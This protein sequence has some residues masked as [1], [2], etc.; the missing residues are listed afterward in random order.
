MV[1][2]AV[3]Y[4]IVLIR[5]QRIFLI[6]NLG[7]LRDRVG[8]LRGLFRLEIVRGTLIMIISWMLHYKHIAAWEY[9]RNSI[10]SYNKKKSPGILTDLSYS[11]QS[12]GL[13]TVLYGIFPAR[14]WHSSFSDKYQGC[15]GQLAYGPFFNRLDYFY[16]NRFSI[17]ILKYRILQYCTFPTIDNQ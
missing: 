4:S 9:F 10:M 5:V 14:T 8:R 3:V 13:R 15:G 17:D 1:W 12:G 2:L 11:L 6:S 7:S 16:W